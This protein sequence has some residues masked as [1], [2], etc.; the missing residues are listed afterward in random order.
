[1][2]EQDK[3]PSWFKLKIERRELL[4][5]LPPEAA[6]KVV[7]ACLDYLETMEQPEDLSELEKIGLAVFQ[8]DLEE[9]WAKYQQRINARKSKDN[10]IGRNRTKS[11][12]TEVETEG[13]VEEETEERSKKKII[14][15]DKPPTR[16]KYGSYKNVLFTDEEY[17]KLQSEFPAD[18]SDRIERLS[19]YMASTGKSYKNHLATI[20]SWAKK[21]GTKP[22]AM[23]NYG[24][25]ENWS[26]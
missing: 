13:E 9:A 14:K 12:D 25:D 3:H 21:D 23:P 26:L 22:G 24:G 4:R 17:T 5:T 20:R 6:V 19:E 10:C 2:A 11:N 18:Y 1:M 7:I 15:A 8:S 16:H